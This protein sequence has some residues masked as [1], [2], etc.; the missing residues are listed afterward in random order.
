MG[1]MFNRIFIVVAFCAFA[2]H[3][4]E[5]AGSSP[6]SETLQGKETLSIR[7]RS[8]DL[9]VVRSALRSVVV[10]CGAALN[11][12]ATPRSSGNVVNLSPRQR[13]TV[14]GAGCFMAVRSQSSRRVNLACLS[15]RPTPT[16]TPT[17]TP[18]STPTEAPTATPTVTP[19]PTATLA[20]N[21]SLLVGSGTQLVSFNSSAPTAARTP[22]AVSGVASGEVLVSIDRRP[23]N[24]MLYGLG[25]NSTVTPRTVQLYLI[26]S[27][28][29]VATAVGATGTFVDALGASVSIGSG[30]STRFGID[31]NP[32]VD[33]LRVVNSAGQNFRI[34]PNTGA[35]I[36]G[37]LGGAASSVSGTNMDGAVNGAS[38]SVQ[39][40]AYTNNSANVSVTTQY[41]LDATADQLFIQNPPN[42]GTQTLAQPLGQDVVAVRGFDIAPGIDVSSS[43]SVASG[44]GVAV[45]ELASNSQQMFCQVNLTTGAVTNAQRIGE[46]NL[47]I[48]G[49]SVQSPNG[50]AM[51]ALASGGASLIRFNSATPSTVSTVAVT[52]ITS[53]ETLVGID[54]RPATGELMGFGVNATTDTGTLYRLDPQTGAASAIGSAGS[55]S[56][57]NSSGS[58]IDFP[59]TGVGYGLDFNPTVDRIRVVTGSGLNFRLNP[60][61]GAAVDSDTTTVANNPDT[62]VSGG[63]TTVHGTSYT[64]SFAQVSGSTV[65]TQYTIDS[66]SGQLFIQNPPNGG[67]QTSAKSIQLGGSS[68]AFTTVLGFQISPEV[69][70][71]TSNSA[72]SSGAAFAALTVGGSTGLYSID[73]STGA[74]TLLGTIGTGA[75]PVA[76]L[77]VAQTSVD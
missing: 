66:T 40:A 34:N 10:R 7:S 32:T 52:G 19:T 70:A 29:G 26:S 59:A 28:T 35:F 47:E 64:N 61:T 57:V 22:F 45:L 72:V 15:A 37:D 54:F 76:G 46:G 74:A 77:A 51:I 2:V 55:I 24:G 49:L 17:G 9:V 13:I 39:E 18:T 25:Y 16:V 4:S 42:A 53:G 27:V 71:T 33:R 68:L 11:R 23:Q 30:A 38:T 56:F 12:R 44:Q 75:T 67:I 60:N 65:T 63:T 6:L 14:Q 8:C 20:S 62:S 50:T 73:L 36:D 58:P 21:V 48:S 5:A 41:T 43:G 3:S 69:R 1:K 31:F